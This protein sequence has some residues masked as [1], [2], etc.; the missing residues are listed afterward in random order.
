MKKYRKAQHDAHASLMAERL[1]F[2]SNNNACTHVMTNII[3]LM[4]DHPRLSYKKISSE[5]RERWF[6][7]WA[8]NFIWDKEHDLIIKKI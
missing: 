2:V 7:K 3:K 1:K 4:Y 5:T 8:L 6:Q